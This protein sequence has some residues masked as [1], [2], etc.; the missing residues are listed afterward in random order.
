MAMELLNLGWWMT[1]RAR[2][3]RRDDRTVKATQCSPGGVYV[4]MCV[5]RAVRWGTMRSELR[6]VENAARGRLGWREAQAVV[7][8]RGW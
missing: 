6:Q 1:E 5:C 2:F 4:C 7:G 3:C 8:A